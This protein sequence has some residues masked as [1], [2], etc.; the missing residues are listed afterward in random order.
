[1]KISI[2]RAT[3]FVTFLSEWNYSLSGRER[4]RKAA[5]AVKKIEDTYVYSYIK[6]IG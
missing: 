1:M 4:K 6:E 2:N 3:E 5:W